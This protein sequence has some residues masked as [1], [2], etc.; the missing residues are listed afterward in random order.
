MNSVK[1]KLEKQNFGD[2]LS[3]NFAVNFDSAIRRTSSLIRSELG[4]IWRR[5]S[6]KYLSSQQCSVSITHQNTSISMSSSFVLGA[7]DNVDAP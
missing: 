1:T 3:E 2:H 7:T 4:I 5:S 6:L